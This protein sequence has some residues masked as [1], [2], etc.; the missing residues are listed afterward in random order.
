MPNIRS[1]QMAM[2]IRTIPDHTTV[3]DKLEAWTAIGGHSARL[4]E[5][6]DGEH[7]IANYRYPTNPNWP[8][9]FG[10][11]VHEITAGEWNKISKRFHHETHD[12]SID[13]ARTAQSLIR[14]FEDL[15]MASIQPNRP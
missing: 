8:N 4:L 1:I 9:S 15:G 3:T 2:R 6:D 5:L 14:I 12:Y 10:N 11:V 7:F 13:D